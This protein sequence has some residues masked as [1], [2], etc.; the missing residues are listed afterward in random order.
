TETQLVGSVQKNGVTSLSF[1]DISKQPYVFKTIVSNFS[2]RGI[3]FYAKSATEILISEKPSSYASSR[4]WQIDTKTGIVT[5][6]ISPAFGSFVRWGSNKDVLFRFSSPNKFSILDRTFSELVP[7]VLITLP[8]KC[9]GGADV[10]Y[11]FVPKDR[12]V[13]VRTNAIPDD[14]FMNKLYTSDDLY[15]I[16]LQSGTDSAVVVGESG[17]IPSLDADNVVSVNNSIYFVNRYD[18]YIYV[19]QHQS[20]EPPIYDY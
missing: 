19:I 18:G 13:F 16:V 6:V 5:L 11:C 4:V 10:V 9:D 1:I 15:K 7:L 20:N 2:M 3:S 14:Y 8:T 17:P 12:G